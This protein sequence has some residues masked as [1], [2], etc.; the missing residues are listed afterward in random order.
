[1]PDESA[2]FVSFPFI[3]INVSLFVTIRSLLIALDLTS[4]QS[5]V[6]SADRERKN[7]CASRTSLP[8]SRGT[9]FKEYSNLYFV[10]RQETFSLNF[11]RFAE[12][13]ALIREYK[14]LFFFL[15]A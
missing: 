14:H 13:A 11:Q 7:T 2:G 9:G 10:N 5:A 12:S 1:M 3:S 8:R 6:A 4:S 15:P